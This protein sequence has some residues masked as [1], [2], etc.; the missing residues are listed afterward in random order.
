MVDLAEIHIKSLDYLAGGN[1][2]N[3]FNCGTGNG[4]SNKEI[5]EK[6]KEISQ[7]DF[8]VE[9]G[10]RRPGDPDTIYADNTKIKKVLNWEP[11]HSDLETIIKTAWTWHKNHPN[12]YV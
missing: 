5:I 3:F 10:P 9:I 1:E 12:G 4:Y 7:V 6:I 2:S 8:K 11:K